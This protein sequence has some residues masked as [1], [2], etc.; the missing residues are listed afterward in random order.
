[1][2][3]KMGMPSRRFGEDK[4]IFPYRDSKS[5]SFVE[6]SLYRLRYSLQGVFSLWWELTNPLDNPSCQKLWSIYCVCA[7]RCRHSPIKSHGLCRASAL[8]GGPML[9][10][11]QDHKYLLETSH[12]QAKW[13]LIA[14]LSEINKSEVKWLMS[15]VLPHFCSHLFFDNFRYFAKGLDKIAISNNWDSCRTSSA[16]QEVSVKEYTV[17]CRIQSELLTEFKI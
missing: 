9:Q 6:W 16:L 15:Y 7:T 1:M 10:N 12:Q 8:H 5:L 2:N 4:N 3:R 17:P 13:P 14:I 11:K